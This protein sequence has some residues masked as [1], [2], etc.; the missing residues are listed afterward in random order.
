MRIAPYQSAGK[1]PGIGIE[2]QL[3]GV[4]AVAVLGFMGP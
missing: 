4:E 2:Q 1:P 3:V